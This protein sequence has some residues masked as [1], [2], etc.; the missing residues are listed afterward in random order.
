MQIHAHFVPNI[1]TLIVVCMLYI[2]TL[3]IIEGLIGR[4]ITK[5]RLKKAT[6]AD[7]LKRGQGSILNIVRLSSGNVA[8]MYYETSEDSTLLVLKTKKRKIK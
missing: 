8:M 6:I 5:R 7:I 1:I 4:I 3:T 2:T